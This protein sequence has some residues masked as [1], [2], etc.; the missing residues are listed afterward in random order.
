MPCYITIKNKFTNNFEKYSF[1]AIKFMKKHHMIKKGDE[2]FRKRRGL[3]MSNAPTQ[4]FFNKNPKYVG[5]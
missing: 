2:G 3:A 5:I 1:K 4:Y